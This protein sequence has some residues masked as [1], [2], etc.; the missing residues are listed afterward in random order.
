MTQR[1]TLDDLDHGRIDP[2]GFDH[3]G[4]IA[5]ACRALACADFFA[6]SARVADGLRVL[7]RRAGAEQKFSATVIHAFMALIAERMSGADAP[8]GFGAF[9]AANPDLLEGSALGRFY[10]GARLADPR[11]RRTALFPDLRG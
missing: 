6:A 7:T 2:A 11:A 5:R 8:G 4:H 9:R 10:S 3:R 1:P